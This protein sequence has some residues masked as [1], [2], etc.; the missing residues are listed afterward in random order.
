MSNKTELQKVSENTM[1]FMRGKYVL[2]EVG[3]G[4]DEL[5]FRRR[6]KK[7]M[8]RVKHIMTVNGCS[9][10]L[11]ICRCSRLSSSLF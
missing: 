5:K 7:F 2:D 9:F 11:P 4:K 1:C 10:P 8:I 6:Y 3:N